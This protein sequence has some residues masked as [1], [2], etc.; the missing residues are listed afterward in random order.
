MV[1]IFFAL[2]HSFYSE[3]IRT[4]PSTSCSAPAP[5]ARVV[6]TFPI[7]PLVASGILSEFPVKHHDGATTAPALTRPSE[8]LSF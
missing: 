2:Y 3:I 6:A 7:E 5:A 4:R 8:L 1:F